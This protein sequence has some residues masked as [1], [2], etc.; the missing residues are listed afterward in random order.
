M[1]LNEQLDDNF[2][3]ETLDL[4]TRTAFLEAAKWSKGLVLIL[5]IILGLSVIAVL[6]S[7]LFGNSGGVAIFL[8]IFMLLFYGIPFYYLY[9]FTTKT[10]AAI[11]SL[12]DVLF[13]SALQN[14]KSLFKFWGIITLLLIAYYVFAILAVFVNI[15]AF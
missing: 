6:G 7:I 1:D 11:E 3:E 12:D 15:N 10:K 14:L 5:G 4:K 2:N 13:T 8:L 9:Q